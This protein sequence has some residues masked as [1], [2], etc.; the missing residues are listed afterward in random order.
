MKYDWIQ[1]SKNSFIV[2][3]KRTGTGDGGYLMARCTKEADAK[4]ITEGLNK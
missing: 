2:F 1:I 4:Q 3:R